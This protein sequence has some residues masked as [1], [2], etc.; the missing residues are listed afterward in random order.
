MLEAL[1]KLAD[2]IREKA[3][4]EKDELMECVK[5]LTRFHHGVF[6]KPVIT[7]IINVKLPLPI[8]T[9]NDKNIKN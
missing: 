5:K 1:C 4:E 6:G 3:P 9:C 8:R 7:G 2:L